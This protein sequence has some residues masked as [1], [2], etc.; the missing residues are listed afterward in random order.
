MFPAGRKWFKFPGASREAL[1]AL[2]A[3]AGVELPGEYFDLLAFSNGGEGPLD[4][5][6]L[7]FCLDSAEDALRRNQV[8]KLYEEFFPG[9]FVFGTSGGGEYIA[10]DLR[11]AR[12]WPVVAID[13]TNIDLDESVDPIAVDFKSF[14]GHVGVEGDLSLLHP[15]WDA[16]WADLELVQP[17]G[18][19]G[20]VAARYL[21]PHRAYH[22][23]HH[24]RECFALFAEARP[25]C[26]H[27]G[28]V[29]LAL[30]LHDAVY[31]PRRR[32]SEE[33]SARWARQL[34]QEAG[35]GPGVVE[36]VCEL[37]LATKH[38]AKPAGGDAAVLVDIDL[39]ILGA[40]PVRF[41]EY[42]AQVRREYAHVP[43]LLFRPG[44]GK[45]L[46]GFLARP[47]IYSTPYFKDRFE[48]RARENIA[49]SLARL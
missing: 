3:G 38:D 21:E 26:E 20:E 34:V 41:D 7:N 10:F 44:R 5:M 33:A 46:E 29:A 43:D 1:E 15:H 40:D 8:E 48:A 17:V 32:D 37:I 4:V 31:E 13:A 2:R 45:I 22:T 28:E 14:L 35:A 16:A 23:P 47:S 30:F 11:G 49:R 24:L 9:F 6:P 27:P 19:F 36:R 25:L 12:P 42:E 18:L 39:A